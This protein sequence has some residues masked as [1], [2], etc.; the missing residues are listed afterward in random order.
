MSR[1]GNYVSKKSD[2]STYYGFDVL[3]DRPIILKANKEYKIKSIIKGPTS[4]YGKDGKTSAK[5]QGVRF[6]FRCSAENSN[7]TDIERGQFPEILF[8][9]PR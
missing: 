8:S 6:T 2:T 3:F 9:V 7:G 1:G 4:W 5:C